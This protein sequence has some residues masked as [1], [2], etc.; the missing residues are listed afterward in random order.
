MSVASTQLK[1]RPGV[2]GHSRPV[3]SAPNLSVVPSPAAPRGFFTT[4]VICVMLFVG[5]LAASFYLNTAMVQG[6]YDISA[7]NNELATVRIQEE[8]LAGQAAGAATP[9]KLQARAEQMGMVPAKSLAQI[10]L[11]NGTVTSMQNGN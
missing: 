4:V 2:Q 3:V 11:K 1:V 6:A 8:T 9:E 5:A 7:L 10:D